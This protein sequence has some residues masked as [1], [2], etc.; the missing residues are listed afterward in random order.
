MFN[1]AVPGINP[2]DADKQ[3]ALALQAEEIIQHVKNT[4]VKGSVI[5]ALLVDQLLQAHNA[6]PKIQEK[7][8]SATA[9]GP[10]FDKDGDPDVGSGPDL[11][12]TRAAVMVR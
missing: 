9:F 11:G 5:T 2:Q 12:T 10:R 8:V 6:L 3:L 1:N 7:Q 4:L